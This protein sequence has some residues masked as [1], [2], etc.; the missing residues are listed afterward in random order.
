[1]PS[2]EQLPEAAAIQGTDLILLD[3]S[4]VAKSASIDLMQAAMAG[5]MRAAM[6]TGLSPAIVRK[7]KEHLVLLCQSYMAAALCKRD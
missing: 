1:M 3:Q 4:G 7:M 5:V 6:E 2:L